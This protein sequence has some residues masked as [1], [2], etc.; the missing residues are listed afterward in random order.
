MWAHHQRC[1]QK[2]IGLTLVAILGVACSDGDDIDSD[3]EARRAYF[4]LD[5]S[6]EKSFQLGFAGFNAA[7]SANIDPQSAVGDEAGTLVVSG[8]VDQG[9]SA[10]KGMRLRIAMV[11]YTDGEV[12][13]VQEG[14]DD[15]KV[16]IVYDTDVDVMLQPYFEI[17]LAGIP[18]GTFTGSLTGTYIMDGDLEGKCDL[19]L[20]FA[21][22]LMSNGT[23]GTTR[24][25]LMTTVTGTAKSGDG[26][27][28]V[29]ITL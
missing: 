21:G 26:T 14:K 17:K 18:D 2:L 4:G 27:Y 22:K 28:D 10:N 1:M 7:S 24:V 19:A 15:V 11:D 3:E 5:A 8:Q 20:T 29:N 23:G 12:T 9:A 16:N 6:V 13:I 25:P